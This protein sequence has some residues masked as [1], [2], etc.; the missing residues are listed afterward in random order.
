MFLVFSRNK[1]ERNSSYEL[2]NI[3]GGAWNHTECFVI[4][5]ES[6]SIDRIRAH[7]LFHNRDFDVLEENLGNSN[8]FLSKNKRFVGSF[9]AVASV[10]S[11]H[12]DL[13]GQ[14]PSAPWIRPCAVAPKSSKPDRSVLNCSIDFR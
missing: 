4:I 2:G 14:R 6:E 8:E 7:A 13:G 9:S 1:I 11:G 12:L 10:Y 5:T 3:D